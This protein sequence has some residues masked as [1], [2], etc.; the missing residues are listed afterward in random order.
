MDRLQHHSQWTFEECLPAPPPHQL[1]GRKINPP[2]WSDFPPWLCKQYHHYSRLAIIP[3]KT[4]NVQSPQLILLHSQT[5]CSHWKVPEVRHLTCGKEKRA[6]YLECPSLLNRNFYSK[7]MAP[8][9]PH[10]K[11]VHGGW[12]APS[13]PKLWSGIVS[14]PPPFT[15]DFP[16]RIRCPRLSGQKVV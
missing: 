13:P 16:R 1:H 3:S 5:E 15:G 14:F 8:F 12:A 2:P 11:D 6:A 9:L 10:L 4:L 7:T